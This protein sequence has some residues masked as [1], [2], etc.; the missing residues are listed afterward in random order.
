MTRLVTTTKGLGRLEGDLI[1]LLDAPYADLG[2]ALVAGETV[3]SLTAKPISSVV[4]TASI[5]LLA[6]VSS[7]S[8]IWIMGWAYH[9]HRIETGQQATKEPFASL[10]APTAVTGPYDPIR[11]PATAPDK[12][13]YEGELG[14]VIG[15]Q[16]SAIAEDAAWSHIAGFT[17]INDVSARD[18]QKGELGGQPANVNMAKSFDTFMPMGPCLAL[19]DEFSDPGDL[20]LRTW[21]D[22]ELRQEARTSELI[23]SIPHLISFL[24]T[25]TTLRPGDV[26]STGTPGGVGH[27]Q[28]KFLR[29][30][31]V[32][33]VEIEGVGAIENVVI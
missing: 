19:L 8:K 17:V 9:E 32:V 33:R 22:G 27:K 11:R 18:V 14:V 16:A 1:A 6:P 10:V 26:I 24:S 4:P 2:A 30:G 29:S 3:E 15:K 31:S 7:P 5:R 13:D 20:L 28:G 23:W 25:F 12:V 21:V